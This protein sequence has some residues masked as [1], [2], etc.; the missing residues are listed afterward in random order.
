VLKWFNECK[1]PKSDDI[2]NEKKDPDTKKNNS[3]N[4]IKDHNNVFLVRQGGTEGNLRNS[5]SIPVL[6]MN[7][8][9]SD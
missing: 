7:I 9:D 4:T 8:L 5:S 1:V 2:L 6:E 3:T